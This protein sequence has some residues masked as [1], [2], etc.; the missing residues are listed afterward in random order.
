MHDLIFD[1]KDDG[2]IP[3]GLRESEIFVL[4]CLKETTG[5][6]HDGASDERS[7]ETERIS[8]LRTILV[9]KFSTHVAINTRN[10]SEK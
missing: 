3:G 10:Q 4:L 7:R 1:I 9:H 6:H 5:G 2:L 8:F